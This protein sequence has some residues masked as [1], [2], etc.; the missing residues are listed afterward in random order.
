[1]AQ[2]AS[3]QVFRTTGNRDFFCKWKSLTC[4]WSLILY[5]NLSIPNASLVSLTVTHLSDNA[6]ALVHPPLCP[7]PLEATEKIQSP[8]ADGH[9]TFPGAM[10]FSLPYGGCSPSFEHYFIA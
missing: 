1:M 8:R 5:E 10:V 7:P 6:Y 3:P 9:L 2:Q 4:P